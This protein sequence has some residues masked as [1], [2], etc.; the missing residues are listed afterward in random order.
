MLKSTFDFVI[1]GI[2]VNCEIYG[3]YEDEHTGNTKHM[4]RVYIYLLVQ[5]PGI[6]LYFL[7]SH[8][9]IYFLLRTSSGNCIAVLP[10]SYVGH[11]NIH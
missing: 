1:R 4:M 7:Y 3:I 9:C 11:N 2:V 5:I 10:F 8:I 6:Q